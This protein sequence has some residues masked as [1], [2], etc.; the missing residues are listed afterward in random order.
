[1][2]SHSAD[3]LSAAGHEVLIFDRKA[4]PWLRPDQQML[5][6]DILD[7]DLVAR[8]VA[9]AE[10]VY[11]YAGLADLN[12]ANARPVD[13]VRLNILGNVNIL[14]ASRLAGVRRFIFASSLY[15]YGRHGGFYRCSKQASEL[16]VENYW[17]EYGLEYTILRYGSLYGPRS[18]PRNGIHGFV[19][20][21]L[22][23]GR[24]E[25]Y[26]TPEALREYIHVEDAALSSVD[27]L[28]PRYANCNLV[29]TGQQAMKV[30]DLFKM[31][32]EILGRPIECSYLSNGRHVHY[33]V[34]PYSF[35]PRM[36]QKLS[37]G[38]VTDLGQGV[39]AI[40]EE[41]YRELNPDPDLEALMGAGP[42]Y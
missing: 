42:D 40:M 29:L 38:R 22:E 9:G 30:S 28:A 17:R 36:G 19:R 11:N 6:G 41:I 16:Y 34:S 31:I 15:V 39:L 27:I 18:D 14:E 12:E 1:M 35:Q 23:T 10:A 33:D 26:G 3:K 7:E 13:S 2:G 8:A 20:Q 21:A 25:Y 5:V 24:I 32:G 37:P 4:S